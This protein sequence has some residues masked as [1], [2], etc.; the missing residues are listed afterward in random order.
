MFVAGWSR[1]EKTKFR[2][3]QYSLPSQP[4][5]SRQPRQQ[6]G[7][8]QGEHQGGLCANLRVLQGRHSRGGSFDQDSPS[9][10]STPEHSVTTRSLPRI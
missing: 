6:Q 9:L 5:Q 4:E 1:I 3:L 7:E 2:R 10:V 8:C